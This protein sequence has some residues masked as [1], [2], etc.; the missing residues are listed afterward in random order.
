MQL[1]M[2]ERKN[3]D[4][5]NALKDALKINNDFEIKL[6]KEV[7]ELNMKMKKLESSNKRLES[8]VEDRKSK[9]SEDFEK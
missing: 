1:T 2:K 7:K 5:E 3:E 6:N 9:L 4:Q 8:K